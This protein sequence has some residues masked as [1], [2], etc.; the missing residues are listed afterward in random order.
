MGMITNVWNGPD[1]EFIQELVVSG[2]AAE[3][4]TARL[5]ALAER[6][7]EVESEFRNRFGSSATVD[8]VALTMDELESEVKYLREDNTALQE[9][10]KYLETRNMIQVLADMQTEV[11][12]ARSLAAARQSEIYRLVDDRDRLKDKLETWTI[13]ST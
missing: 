9:R 10:V 3:P 5:I 12:S 13:L 7:N 2:L 11:D 4:V 6:Q 1:E 8:Q